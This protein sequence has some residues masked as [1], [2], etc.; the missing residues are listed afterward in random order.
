[1]RAAR[2]RELLAA[3]FTVPSSQGFSAYRTGWFVHCA[4]SVLLAEV[5]CVALGLIGVSSLPLRAA[6]ALLAVLLAWGAGAF[7]GILS[8]YNPLLMLL[9]IA[10]VVASFRLFGD[11]APVGFV[12]GVAAHSAALLLLSGVQRLRRKPE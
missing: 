8:H 6:G 11:F 12:I 3:Y 4:F 7:L 5:A 1:M 2:A 9:A 10:G